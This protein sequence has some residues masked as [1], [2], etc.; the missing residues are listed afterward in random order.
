MLAFHKPYGHS[1]GAENLLFGIQHHYVIGKAKGNTDINKY[2]RPE[3]RK[4]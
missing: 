4:D 1:T 2:A 3:N